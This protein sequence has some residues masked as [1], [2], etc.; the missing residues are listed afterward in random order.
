MKKKSKLIFELLFL[1]LGT[2]LLLWLFIEPLRALFRGGSFLVIML[3]VF[4]AVI[5]MYL[6]RKRALAELRL[7]NLDKAKHHLIQIWVLFLPSAIVYIF[8]TWLFRPE[9][10]FYLPKTNTGLWL[11]IMLAYPIFSVLPQGIIYRV[12]FFYRYQS[13]FPNPLI[14]IVFAAFFFSFAHIFFDNIFALVFT[15][16]GGLLFAYRYFKT[17]SWLLSS[18][19]HALYGNLFFTIGLGEFLMS[20]GG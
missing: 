17:Q 15:F 2:P 18:L 13:L 16:L 9:S 3:P 11:L 8:F 1:F 20:G 14:L 7:F 10:L 19:E 6:R 12:F 4:A 5:L